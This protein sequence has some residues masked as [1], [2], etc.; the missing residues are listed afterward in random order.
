[1]RPRLTRDTVIVPVMLRPIARLSPPRRRQA[2][3]P[4]GRAIRSSREM[5][6]GYTQ[7]P[8]A[9]SRQKIEASCDGES[10]NYASTTKAAY[11]QLV[12]N[13]ATPDQTVFATAAASQVPGRGHGE[14]ASRSG[15]PP[16]RD[17]IC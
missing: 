7:W 15:R 1:M 9:G 12:Q 8:R 4:G 17:L 5:S 6:Q 13:A 10:S 14:D 11:A 2:D 16:S 3:N